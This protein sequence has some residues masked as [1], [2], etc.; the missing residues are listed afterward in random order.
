MKNNMIFKVRH[1]IVGKIIIIALFMCLYFSYELYS[2]IPYQILYD[3]YTPRG[4]I[5][6]S[7]LYEEDEKDRRDSLDN[8]Y[9]VKFPSAEFFITTSDSTSSTKLFNCHSYAWIVYDYGIVRYGISVPYIFINDSS[10]VETTSRAYPCKL[11]YQY[12]FHSAVVTPESGYFISKWGDGPLAKHR[13]GHLYDPYYDNI[14]DYKYAKYYRLNCTSSSI[15]LGSSGNYD[16]IY[17]YNICSNSVFMDTI[18]YGGRCIT[19]NDTIFFKFPLNMWALN[20]ATW[21]IN[22][23]PIVYSSEFKN[24]L[25]IP[26]KYFIFPLSDYAHLWWND[27]SADYMHLKAVFPSKFIPNDKEINFKFRV[28]YNQEIASIFANFWKDTDYEIDGNNISLDAD[29]SDTLRISFPPNIPCNLELP[30]GMELDSN[31][32]LVIA[33]TTECDLN[34]PLVYDCECFGIFTMNIHNIFCDIEEDCD[35]VEINYSCGPLGAAP[36]GIYWPEIT[37]GPIQWQKYY[38]CT[39]GKA[40]TNIEIIHPL[41]PLLDSI[42][43]DV[44]TGTF[45]IF[46]S[47]D[48]C[49][50]L[51]NLALEIC[52]YFDDNTY[53][54]KEKVV[55]FLCSDHY[56]L[57]F[58]IIPNPTDGYASIEYEINLEG[59]PIEVFI[60]DQ[61]GNLILDLGNFYSFSLTGSIPM[62]VSSLISGSYYA[63]IKYG[64]FITSIFFIKQ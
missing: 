63:V 55:S 58:L 32:Y 19:S 53:C 1:N 45:E 7:W 46:F 18:E 27:T 28:N 10:Y 36:D 2:Q 48:T 14:N 38:I 3:I 6:E 24:A 51:H 8:A 37:A 56:I 47:C 44:L 41:H 62:D 12:D 49:Y 35:D 64:N 57:P 25:Q 21:Y 13:L 17:N 22:D 30:K 15:L 9:N 54:C 42:K 11:V 39:E 29:L 33:P 59:V 20:F 50:M 40:I 5:V 43:S 52:I 4:S 31:N 61:S 16:T 23:I 60:Y 26:G 34:I